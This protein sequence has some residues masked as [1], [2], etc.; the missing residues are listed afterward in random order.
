MSG[1]ERDPGRPVTLRADRPAP[2]ISLSARTLTPQEFIIIAGLYFPYLELMH[3]LA[4]G[5]RESGLYTAAWNWNPPIED[6]R[7]LMQINAL[8]WPQW[9]AWNHFDPQVNLYFAGLI[10][11][12]G[13]WLPWRAD[14]PHPWP[15]A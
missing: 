14:G 8:A 10:Y 2:P 11:K 12:S 3:A 1:T 15:W 4:I 13:G 5:Q 6:S 7:G 9:A